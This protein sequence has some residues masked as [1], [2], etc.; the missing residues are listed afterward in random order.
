MLPFPR[1]IVSDFD[2]TVS[3]FISGIETVLELFTSRGVPHD[4]A[5]TSWQAAEERGFSLRVFTEEIEL[6]T[7]RHFAPSALKVDF[8]KWM[9]KNIRPY[10]D[11]FLAFVAWQAL[12]IPVIFVSF[13]DTVYQRDKIALSTL[14]HTGMHIV[15][16]KSHKVNIVREI[17]RLYGP[18]IIHLEDDV[19]IL[20]VIYETGLGMQI[21]TIWVH[22]PDSPYATTPARYPHLVITALTDLSFSNA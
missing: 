4:V 19:T 6:R 3:H 16:N 11:S 12:R 2:F 10:E 1:A 8:T 7:S 14:P 22:R 17:L 18:P 20:D 5:H 9:I 15:Q 13:G 21:Q